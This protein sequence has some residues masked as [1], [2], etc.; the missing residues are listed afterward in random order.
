[1]KVRMIYKGG[2]TR[3]YHSCNAPVILQVDKSISVLVFLESILDILPLIM[4]V[5]DMS[6]LISQS[7]RNQI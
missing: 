2:A 5:Q 1:M 3:S 7:T 6:I 4:W